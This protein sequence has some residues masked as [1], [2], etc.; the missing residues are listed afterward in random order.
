MFDQ[1]LRQIGDLALGSVPTMIIFILLVIAYR[2]ILYDSLVKTLSDRRERT[3]GAIEAAAAA[4]AQ[5]D[6]KTQEYEAKLRAARAE[7]FHLREQRLQQWVA[8]KDE[9]LASARL[10]AQQR[11]AQARAG[12]EAEADSARRRI[13]DSAGQLAVQI[14]QAVLPSSVEEV[15]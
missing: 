14:V 8:E 2:Y 4:V 11:V 5:A 3:T 12:I 6:A 9:A 7:I 13:E 10:A 1:L 15:R